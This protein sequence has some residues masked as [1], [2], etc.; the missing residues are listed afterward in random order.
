LEQ[1]TFDNVKFYPL[2]TANLG[3]DELKKVI[4]D[5]VYYINI[6]CETNY[7]IDLD[8]TPDIKTVDSYT[9]I[10]ECK[11]MKNG[12]KAT[13][14]SY[15]HSKDIDIQFEDG[16]ISTN[17]TYHC[18]KSGCISHP[19]LSYM[20][21]THINKTNV[22]TNGM[23]ARIIAFRSYTDMDVEFED[24]VI[25]EHVSS[26]SFN[27]GKI[28]HPLCGM[29]ARSVRHRKERLGESKTCKDGRIATIIKYTKC[30]DI[31]VKFDDETEW[32]T[33]YQRF[34]LA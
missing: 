26:E 17:K 7:V 15:R 6:T 34:K 30:D 10:G 14:I 13:I 9:R 20:Y 22:M 25:R 28:R 11:K 32:N 8:L 16:A 24:G 19:T 31:I 1:Y 3:S 27:K 4:G 23:V 21:L 18:F 12:M 2:T 5:I 33:S 29:D